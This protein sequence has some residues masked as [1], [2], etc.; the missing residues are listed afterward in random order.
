M[1]TLSLSYAHHHWGT[2]VRD[3]KP[4]VSLRSSLTTICSIPNNLADV[5]HQLTESF[6]HWHNSL[7]EQ[8]S[9]HDYAQFWAAKAV[10]AARTDEETRRAQ[11]LYC[12]ATVVLRYQEL[13][14]VL[15]VQP[16]VLVEFLRCFYSLRMPLRHRYQ[17]KAVLHGLLSGSFQCVTQY[18]ECSREPGILVMAPSVLG[19]RA[20]ALKLSLPLL[21]IPELIRRHPR[22]LRSEVHLQ[23]PTLP[24]QDMLC[25][26]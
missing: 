20:M 21:N 16:A 22:V 26:R 9:D 2:S 5:P 10:S 6:R 12:L 24:E 8:A 17:P 23:S 19:D 14:R 3:H 25:M 4:A 18:S 11:E 13:V 1:H 7:E 15:G